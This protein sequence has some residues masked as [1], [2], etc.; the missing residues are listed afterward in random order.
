MKN[1]TAE[2]KNSKFARAALVLFGLAVLL[3]AFLGFTPGGRLIPLFLFLVLL[4]SLFYYF[5]FVDERNS[6]L[7]YRLQ[8][9]FFIVVLL[10]LFSA[11]VSRTERNGLE[12]IAEYIEPYPKV[13]EVMYLPRTP[14]CTV[15]QW[16]LT[17][18]DSSNDVAQF[19]SK[20]ENS[21]G[22]IVSQQ[23]GFIF[24]TNERYELTISFTQEYEK[25]RIF[26][27]IKKSDCEPGSP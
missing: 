7:R 20:P 23:G 11:Y 5:G 19:Y 3:T 15:Q 27:L 2:N 18:N 21:A 24:F 16:L 26:Y 25:T 22:W 4:A 14:S 9:G 6:P 12:A 8:G 1:K 13:D 10:A 17:T